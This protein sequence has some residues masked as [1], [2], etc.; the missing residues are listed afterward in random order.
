[1][2]LGDETVEVHDPDRNPVMTRRRWL[3]GAATVAV[4]GVGLDALAIEPQRVTL[5][6]H[7]VGSGTGPVLR[8]VQ[9]SDL[10]LHSVGRHQ[11]HVA[12]AVA[13]LHPDFVL[14]TGDS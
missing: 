5:S 1:M 6:R 4:A 11:E 2:T 7:R 8:I 14:L 13:E 9:L 12:A 10:H 3:L